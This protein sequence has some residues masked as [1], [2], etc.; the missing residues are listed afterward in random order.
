MNKS[1]LYVRI[2]GACVVLS[3]V[4]NYELLVYSFEALKT[5]WASDS[6]LLPVLAG[7]IQAL[8]WL[9]LFV[10]GGLLL[11]PKSMGK[12]VLL[13]SLLLSL[14]GGVFIAWVPGANYIGELLNS[15]RLSLALFSVLNAGMLFLVFRFTRGAT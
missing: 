3:I 14:V 7:V 6:G 15:P 9:V 1:D 13:A 12:W 4:V 10:G 8:S 11:I 5:L 2:I